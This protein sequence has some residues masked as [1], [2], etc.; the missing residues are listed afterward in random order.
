M[1]KDGALDSVTVLV[2]A[3]DSATVTALDGVTVATED[4]ATVLLVKVT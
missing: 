1:A 3:V 4:N 2:T